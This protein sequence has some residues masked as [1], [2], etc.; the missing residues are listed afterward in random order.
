MCLTDYLRP[1]LGS[2]NGVRLFK[3][4][5]KNLENM[6]SNFKIEIL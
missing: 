2:P 5:L 1:I 6:S 4:R 3:I